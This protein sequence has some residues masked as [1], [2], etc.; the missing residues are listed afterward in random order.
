ML[1]PLVVVTPLP[2]SNALRCLLLQP[3][4]KSILADVGKLLRPS[5][6][7]HLRGISSPSLHCQ[8]LCASL[9]LKCVAYR[10]QRVGSCVLFVI[11]L[12]CL[13]IGAFSSYTLRIIIDWSETL[14]L[15]SVLW[16]FYNSLFF[17]LL[18]CS[19]LCLMIFCSG[20][21]RFLSL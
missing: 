4:C 20:M 15:V 19:S 5:S 10:Q 17:F 3:D 7:F 14:I 8:S 6:G 18:L 12:L 21:L 16:L 11:Q 9:K 2:F 1:Y 13:L